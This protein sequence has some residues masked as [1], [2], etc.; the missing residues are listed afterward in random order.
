[1]LHGQHERRGRKARPC[2]EPL[3]DRIVPSAAPAPGIPGAA[4]AVVH[5]VAHPHAG[6][7]ARFDAA[8][9]R[10]EQQGLARFEQASRSVSHRIDRLD[11]MV[12]NAEDRATAPLDTGATPGTRTAAV[13][14][15]SSTV[16]IARAF[17]RFATRFEQQWNQAVRSSED[18]FG[19]VVQRDVR[20]DPALGP[21]GLAAQANFATTEAARGRSLDG[22][23]QAARD[24]LQSSIS[25]ARATAAANVPARQTTTAAA[26]G[27]ADLRAAVSRVHRAPVIPHPSGVRS[28]ATS[29]ATGT[30]TTT[31]FLA[32]GETTMFG[33]GSAANGSP[34]TASG[35][36]PLY[37]AT[38]T[39]GTGGIPGSTGS[40]AFGVGTFGGNGDLLG[41]TV[42]S[43]VTGTT[44]A[45]VDTGLETFGIG[46]GLGFGTGIDPTPNGSEGFGLLY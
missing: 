6:P 1:M 31:P 36:G 44:G 7:V 24:N 12:Q 22:E 37:T 45:G 3:D 30:A 23:L 4:V 35:L 17:D 18:R 38:G 14:L 32:A 33:F 11:A 41:G 46:N 8:V 20:T 26:Q 43:P 2:L 5:A 13:R 21:T 40:G 42:P 29:A 9:N 19:R 34:V 28:A 10:F 25:S 16:T 15:T 39:V 27:V